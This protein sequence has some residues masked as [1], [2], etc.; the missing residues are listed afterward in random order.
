MIPGLR[1]SP[2][3]GNGNRLG[4]SCLEN[5]MDRGAWRAAV[6]GLQRLDTTER[7][8][9]SQ[10]LSLSLRVVSPVAGRRGGLHLLAFIVEEDPCAL[11][12]GP[13]AGFEG[14]TSGSGISFPAGFYFTFCFHLCSSGC[15]LALSSSFQVVFPWPL[16]LPAVA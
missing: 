6:Q 14:R 16:L 1:R 11:Q 3:E 9:L 8:T 13:V 10:V 7:L 12:D 4:Y 5:P 2:G 15:L